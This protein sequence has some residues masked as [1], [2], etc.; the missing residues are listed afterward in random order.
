M[1]GGAALLSLR[2]LPLPWPAARAIAGTPAFDPPVSLPAADRPAP[3]ARAGDR[4]LATTG[5]APR[6]YRPEL[7]A[8]RF[9]AFALVFCDHAHVYRGWFLPV[10]EMGAFGL[11]IFFSLSA[12]LLA[13]L[14]LREREATGTVRLRAFAARRA[15]RIWP[16]YFAVI[17]IALALG[18]F[19][20]GAR[21]DR[22]Y[23]LSLSLLAGN[24]FILQHGW[25]GVGVIAPL[26]SVSLEEQFYL[27]IPLLARFGGKRAIAAFSGVSLSVAYAVLWWLGH[28][29]AT[30]ISSVWANS[31][32]Q[33][34]FFAAGALIA[35][36]SY[37][38][39][40][41]LGVATRS[42]LV[43]SGILCFLV[44]AQH[45][46]L[47]RWTP[48]PAGS[49]M[50]GYLLV[51]LGTSAILI[52]ALDFPLRLPRPVV[53]LGKISFGLY[54]FHDIFMNLIFGNAQG[55]PRL[56]F[57]VAN[58]R[59]IGLIMVFACTA[60]AASFSYRFFE[61]PFLGLK[62]RFEVLKTRPA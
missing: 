10:R 17:G 57:F 32:V 29:G 38:R 28:R 12:Y 34:Q 48:V 6:F 46:G 9:F 21:A 2:S 54:L 47:H 13:T 26:W 11:C 60:A 52:A 18:T 37:R 61:R 59:G 50:V 41:R 35:L 31:F 36:L 14:L 55:W 42:L 25:N 62:A 33:A 8:L 4:T 22:H 5:A 43:A 40:V 7:D 3:G 45:Y 20:A 44:A 51:L 49:L 39:A 27:L 56:V 58:H 53:D 24:L 19:W 23:L 16:L 15:L 30:P 1:N